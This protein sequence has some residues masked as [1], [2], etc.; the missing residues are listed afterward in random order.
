MYHYHF[1]IFSSSLQQQKPSPHVEEFSCSTPHRTG[2]PGFF[3]AMPSNVSSP[4]SAVKDSEVVTD[5]TT[6]KGKIKNK[7]AQ[8]VM[9][10]LR[11]GKDLTAKQGLQGQATAIVIDDECRVPNA[12]QTQMWISELG[13]SNHD[14]ECLLSDGW[15]TDSIVN[16][17]QMLLRKSNPLISGLQDVTLGLTMCFEVE[18]EEFV[19]ILHNG[20]GH[21]TISTVGVKHPSVEFFDSL[22]STCPTE[23]KAQVAALLATQHSY[24][25]LTYMDVHMQAGANDCGLFAIA[26]ATAVVFAEKPGS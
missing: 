11:H 19:Q 8:T 12:A 10:K 13:L 6:T 20:A 22:P 23:S 26:F 24:F 5:S 17:A 25:Q 15:L 16:A 18:S 14:R 9:F 1:I 7:T 2:S 4:I 21:W 3:P